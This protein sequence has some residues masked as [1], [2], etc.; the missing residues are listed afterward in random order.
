MRWLLEQE[1]WF[2]EHKPS[3]F[4]RLREEVVLIP[5]QHLLGKHSHRKYLLK[6]IGIEPF[7]E[8]DH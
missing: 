7:F 3:I 8:S 5:N 4:K 2:P 6:E 1:K